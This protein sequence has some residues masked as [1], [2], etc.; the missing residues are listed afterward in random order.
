MKNILLLIVLGLIAFAGSAAAQTYV[1]EE[2]Y[3][4]RVGDWR[5]S[6]QPVSFNMSASLTHTIGSAYL[7][8]SFENF[9]PWWQADLAALSLGLLWE[10]KDGL[11]P[12][13]AGGVIG[14]EGFSYNDFKMDLLGVL[15]NRMLPTLLEKSFSAVKNF[16]SSKYSL[17]FSSQEYPKLQLSVGM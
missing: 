1:P 7:A 17:G 16:D 6:K 12:W 4:L 8:N 3:S 11:V 9:M 15:I 10:V 2:D 13:E 5:V 14:G